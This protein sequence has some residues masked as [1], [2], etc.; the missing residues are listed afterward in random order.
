M[1]NFLK[2]SL[3]ILVILIIIDWIFNMGIFKKD[4]EDGTQ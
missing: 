3:I 4:K 2:D 1:K